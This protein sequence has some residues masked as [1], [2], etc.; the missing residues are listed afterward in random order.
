MTEKTIYKCDGPDCDQTTESVIE[1]GWLT[2]SFS[3]RGYGG[4]V[5][6]HF[7][8]ENCLRQHFE[9]I[10]VEDVAKAAVQ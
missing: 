1:P 10:A 3:G 6:R 8:G 5:M 2:L 7:C 9:H 4:L